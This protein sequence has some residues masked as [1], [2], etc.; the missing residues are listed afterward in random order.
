MREKD[1]LVVL[2]RQ[3]FIVVG[4]KPEEEA[5][6]DLKQECAVSKLP[7]ASVRKDSH[8]PVFVCVVLGRPMRETR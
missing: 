3:G 8:G 6:E 5:E 7:V 2:V 4:E 1:G